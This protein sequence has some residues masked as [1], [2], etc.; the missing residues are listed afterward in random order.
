MGNLLWTSTG[1]CIQISPWE[2]FL[3]ISLSNQWNQSKD[4]VLEGDSKIIDRINRGT[5]MKVE[6][7]RFFLTQLHLYC[8]ACNL[9]NHI[10]IKCKQPN[11]LF[12]SFCSAELSCFL[13]CPYFLL[14][15]LKHS[16]LLHWQLN[17]GRNVEVAR[18][19][20]RYNAIAGNT[21]AN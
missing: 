1:L 18:Q 9:L 12:S 10:L 8:R 19:D 13:R 7:K 16:F 3:Q 11:T 2:N 21:A 4:N 14:Q 17:W 20:S 5:L 15:K 6:L